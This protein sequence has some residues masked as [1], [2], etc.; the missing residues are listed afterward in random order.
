M[1]EN[2]KPL[3]LYKNKVLVQSLIAGFT[4]NNTIFHGFCN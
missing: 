3:N 4:T 1:K 2:N